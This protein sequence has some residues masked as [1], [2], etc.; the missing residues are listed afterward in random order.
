MIIA[1]IVF[2][3]RNTL[4]TPFSR[5]ESSTPC[6]RRTFQCHLISRHLQ[7]CVLFRE[8]CYDSGSHLPFVRETLERAHNGVYCQSRAACCDRADAPERPFVRQSIRHSADCRRGFYGDLVTCSRSRLI[9]E[10]CPSQQPE[11]GS[12]KIGLTAVDDET[13]ATSSLRKWIPRRGFRKI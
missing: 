10:V 13:S 9:K 7:L 2:C 6:G 11:C 8:A 3:S 5:R 4:R 12:I 1:F